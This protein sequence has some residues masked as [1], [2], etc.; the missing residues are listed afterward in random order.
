MSGPAG[1]GKSRLVAEALAGLDNPTVV[2]AR[3]EPYGVTTP[4][5]PF[6]DL[7]RDLLG[8]ERGAPAAMTSV[9]LG[10]LE[11]LAPHLLPFA[12]LVGAVASVEVPAT[13]ETD[14]ITD[15]HRP[16]RTADVV[17][18]LLGVAARGN[19]LVIVMEDAQWA[20]EATTHLLDRICAATTAHPWLAVITRREAGGG[21]V[22]AEGD[23]IELGPLTD[24]KV[25]AL[26]YAAT[27]A[28]PL[29]PHEVDAIVSRA[30]GSP[31]FIEELARAVRTVGFLETV[32]DSIQAALTAQVDAMDNPRVTSS[33]TRPSSVAASAGAC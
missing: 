31:L 8:V 19:P 17:I 14:A 20:D 1:L 26:T 12:P 27:E 29:R 5:R 22:A 11:Q 3:A 16:D 23:R 6:R 9:L 24:A 30:A 28:T 13:P 10:R 33:R 25:R 2:N 4:Y 15:R 32:P 18:E 7:A 21:F